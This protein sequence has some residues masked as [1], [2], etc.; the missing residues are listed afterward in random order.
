MITEMI[1]SRYG[2]W[3]LVLA[4][5]ILLMFCGLIACIV[6]AAKSYRNMKRTIMDSESVTEESA[7]IRD[8]LTITVSDNIVDILEINLDTYEYVY[9]FHE[10]AL[11][12]R[13]IKGE[14]PWGEFLENMIP[15]IHPLDRA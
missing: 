9:V 14:I 11:K 4:G 5:I 13:A 12:I 10:E 6:V 2:V 15:R 7:M 3:V 1:N 8:F